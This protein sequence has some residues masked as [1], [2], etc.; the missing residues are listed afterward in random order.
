MAE[1]LIYNTTHWMDH[2]TTERWNELSAQ[3]PHFQ[4]QYLGR[5]QEGSVVEI[6]PDGFWSKKGVYPRADK[7]RVVLIPGIS[8]AQLHFLMEAGIIF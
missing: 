8:V 1:L 7:F 5:Y 4:E 3:V 2:I 6:R